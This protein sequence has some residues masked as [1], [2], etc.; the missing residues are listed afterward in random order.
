MTGRK[1]INGTTI[2]DDLISILTIY[3][4]STIHRAKIDATTID[5]V[6]NY[7]RVE[8]SRWRNVNYAT[9]SWTKDTVDFVD[10]LWGNFYNSVDN[11]WRRKI[12]L[13]HDIVSLWTFI[14]VLFGKNF[15]IIKKSAGSRGGPLP[16]FSIPKNIEWNFVY[17]NVNYTRNLTLSTYISW[18][19]IWIF[20]YAIYTFFLELLLL[21]LFEKL[22]CLIKC[23][24]M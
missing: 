19:L 1:L 4:V 10:F 21:L 20:N 17:V 6:I 8:T 22:E 12:S 11:N 16:L 23:T 3:N 7:S 14:D 9:H 13:L 2:F 18:G 24:C 5:L 15:R